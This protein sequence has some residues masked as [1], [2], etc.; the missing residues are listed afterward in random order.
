MLGDVQ[1]SNEIQHPVIY[2]DE[3]I[4]V[5]GELQ[6]FGLQLHAYVHKWTPKTKE[7]IRLV[8]AMI[9]VDSPHPVFALATN[10]KLKKFCEIMGFISLDDVYDRKG[11][12]IGELM[13]VPNSGQENDY[14]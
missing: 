10:L 1:S 9:C 14:V 7:H 12:L 8:L 2:E 6:S 4:T 11:N 5:Y 3:V 13:F